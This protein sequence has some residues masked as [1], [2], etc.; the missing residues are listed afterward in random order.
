MRKRPDIVKSRP[1][2]LSI[3]TPAIWQRM[4]QVKALGEEIERQSK[5]AG[6][7]RVEHV[8]VLDNCRRSVGLKRAACQAAARGRYI[9]FCDDDDW[10][11]PDY[12][13]LL[14]GKIEAT[15]AD[16]ITFDQNVRVDSSEGTVTFGINHVDEPWRPNAVVKRAPW[17]V[18]AW[19]AALV[20]ECVWPDLMDG[21]DRIWCEQARRCVRNGAHVPEVLHEYRYNTETT[22][23]TPERRAG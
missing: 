23:A 8:V 12:V 13:E 15:E 17:H 19:K 2:V 3:L 14:L 7:H 6:G 20:A 22:M 1:P 11:R 10:I 4:D 9:A 5:W 21:E 18:C 16:V